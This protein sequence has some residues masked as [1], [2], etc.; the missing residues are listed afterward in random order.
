MLRMY[1]KMRR[2]RERKSVL[3]VLA[4]MFFGV[5]GLAVALFLVRSMKMDE[6]RGYLQAGGNYDLEFYNI[7]DAM[8]EQLEWDELIGRLGRVYEFGNA[9]IAGMEQSVRVGALENEV[10]QELFYV[11]P[12]E[13]HYPRKE[14]EICMNRLTMKECGM[15]GELG[16]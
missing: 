6:L 3:I 8:Q 13:G 9:R 1:W 12:V 15:R 7:S 11:P 2:G 14:S 10:A 4:T 5:F 16:E